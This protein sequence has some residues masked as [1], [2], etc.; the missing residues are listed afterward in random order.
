MHILLLLY[1]PN[2]N[3]K[4]K[5]IVRVAWPFQST[6]WTVYKRGY[7]YLS[8]NKEIAVSFC[9][10]RAFEQWWYRDKLPLENCEPFFFFLHFLFVYHLILFSI[11]HRVW[12]ERSKL[13]ERKTTIT[14][15]QKRKSAAAT[16]KSIIPTTKCSEVFCFYEHFVCFF[17]LIFYLYS[18]FR[19]AKNYETDK[20]ATVRS[21]ISVCARAFSALSQ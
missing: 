6:V 11:V 5:N 20:R 17:P 19:I 12:A 7:E 16:V 8:F 21:V 13:H 9:V 18:I 2:V 3:Q 1:R 4:R 10:W 15:N 14:A